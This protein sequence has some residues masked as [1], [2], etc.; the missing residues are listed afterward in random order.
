MKIHQNNTC[1]VE[2]HY[3]PC[4]QY[5]ALFYRYEAVRLEVCEHYQ[6]GSYRNRCTIA[7]AQGPQVLSVPLVKGKHQ[8]MPIHEVRIAYDMPWHLQ[9]WHA[10]YTAYGKAPFFLHYGETLQKILFR[11]YDRL[12]DLNLSLLNWLVQCLHAPAQIQ[13]STE[14][15]VSPEDAADL[16]N[17]IRPGVMF[18]LPA[19]NQ[20]F[21]DRTGFQS[22]MSALDLLMHLGP[23]GY[24]YLSQIAP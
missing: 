11:Q 18:S 21:S 2:L 16:R 17:M 5:L 4:V 9:Q 24:G 14:Y 15:E 8:Q 23:E 19:Y 7:T 1:L 3:L 12:Y 13:H 10:I 6:K 20:V 22:N